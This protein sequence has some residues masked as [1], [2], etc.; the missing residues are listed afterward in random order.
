M[1]KK[2]RGKTPADGWN[3]VV[4]C[5]CVGEW[6]RACLPEV[7]PIFPLGTLGNQSNSWRFGLWRSF[8]RAEKKFET[9]VGPG[10]LHLQQS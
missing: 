9:R 6:V 1:K 4:V 7:E 2:K 8:W 10:L 3:S 5:A